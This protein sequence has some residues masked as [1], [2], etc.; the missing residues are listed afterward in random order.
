ML[1][2][3]LDAASQLKNFGFAL[4]RCKAGKVK[5]LAADLLV[6]GVSV[7]H[8]CISDHVGKNEPILVAIDA[9]L[10]WPA[11]LSEML[12]THAA[13]K[14][15]AHKKDALF[16]RQTDE[17]VRGITRKAPMEVGADKIA[18]ATHSALEVLHHLRLATG[19]ALPMLWTSHGETGG[20]IEV[21]PGAMLKAMGISATKYKEPHQV[22][23]REQIATSL[24]AI[25]PRLGKYVLKK[26]DVFDACLCLIAASDFLAGRCRAPT[27][28]E[29]PLAEKEGWIWVRTPGA[30]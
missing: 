28:A 15:V 1:I 20:V 27:A 21:Y 25:A 5:I 29:R 2:V 6:D 24:H 18:R 22:E 23:A 4:G 9:P 13:G 8:D 7:F 17:V 26:A 30:K 12:K 3:G 16:R 14:V 19:R 10:G 11:P